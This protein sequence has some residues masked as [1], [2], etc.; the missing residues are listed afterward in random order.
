MVLVGCGGGGG[1]GGGGG[2]GGRVGSLGW[3]TFV[4]S[5]YLEVTY[6]D[7]NYTLHLRRSDLM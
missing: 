4:N 1:G 3:K 2:S 7:N 5:N 6:F